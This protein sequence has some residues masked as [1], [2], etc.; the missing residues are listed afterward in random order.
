MELFDFCL[1]GNT[2]EMS[3]NNI[4]IIGL[5]G[6]AL[7]ISTG[8]FVTGDL[9][10]NTYDEVARFVKFVEDNET[11]KINLPFFGNT[12]EYIS[13]INNDNYILANLKHSGG[14]IKIVLEILAAITRKI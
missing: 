11:F 14:T 2:V 4:N 8:N 7:N 3:R 12:E 10:L 1:I 6:R 5:G 9:S 13:K